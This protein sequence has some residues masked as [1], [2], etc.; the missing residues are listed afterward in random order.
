MRQLTKAEFK[1]E[2]MN[3]LAWQRMDVATSKWAARLAIAVA[4]GAC[5]LAVA[6]VAAV[7]MLSPLKRVEPYVITVDKSTGATNVM[8]AMS[9]A[10]EITADQAVARHFLANYVREREGWIPLAENEAYNHVQLMSSQDER[11]RWVNY[12]AATN[13]NSPQKLFAN[14]PMVA[15]DVKAISFINKQ[16]AQVHYW[17]TVY[18]HSDQPQVTKWIAIINFEITARPA[19]ERDLEINP[20]GFTVNTYTTSAEM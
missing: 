7:A 10:S 5:I 8:K 1:D 11:Q 16:I 15:V 2:T 4:G 17:R 6:S 18:S 9:G 13:P 20:V 14:S 19:L 3:G 12:F